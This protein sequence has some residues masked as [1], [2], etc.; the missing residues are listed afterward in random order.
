MADKNLTA[1]GG[2]TDQRRTALAPLAT[3]SLAELAF[4]KLVEA[5]SEGV[6]EPGQKLSE[7]E[8]ARRFGISRGPLREA[9]HRLEGRL[10][11]RQPRLGVRILDLSSEKLAEL[12]DIR[13]ALEGMSARLAARN[14]TDERV[15]ALRTLLEVHAGD[16]E[17]A[18]GT[19]YRQTRFNEDFHAAVMQLSGNSKL[20]SLMFEE[21]YFQLRLYRY[22]ASEQKGRARQAYRQHVMIVEAIEARDEEAA[23][24][25][26]RE[27]IRSAYHALSARLNDLK[28][29]GSPGTS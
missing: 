22:R 12:F 28:R 18:A 4:E 26:M 6:F 20:Q 5:I 8:L 10:V 1:S 11:V 19:R 29:A 7:A 25:A 2:Q 16:P 9:L 14:A 15:E 17:L 13:E 23:E 21:L 24:A 3:H 27:H